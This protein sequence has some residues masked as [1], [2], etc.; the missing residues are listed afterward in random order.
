MSIQMGNDEFIL[1]VRKIYS[2]C[3]MPNDALGRLIWTR[4]KELDPEA[5]IF[6]EDKPC[7]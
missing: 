2:N 6:E 7:F 4:L 1:Y 5:L 3:L